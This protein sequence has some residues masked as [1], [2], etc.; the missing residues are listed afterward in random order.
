MMNETISVLRTFFLTTLVIL[1]LW[2]LTYPS[3]VSKLKLYS[4]LLDLHAWLYLQEEL[5]KY[6]GDV[7]EFEANKEIDHHIAIY[8]SGDGYYE[9]KKE[10]LTIQTIWPEWPDVQTLKI[11][12]QPADHYKRDDKTIT[13]NVRIYRVKTSSVSN[14]PTSDYFVVFLRDLGVI[15]VVS[16]YDSLFLHNSSLGLRQVIQAAHEGHKPQYWD[17]ISLNLLRHGYDQGIRKLT[18]KSEALAKLRAEANPHTPG[19]VELFGIQ[20]SIYLFF[21]S[22]G[23]LL[24]A[25]AFAMIG[26]IMALVSADIKVCRHPWIFLLPF[27]RSILGGI[28]E[29]TIFLVLLL[30]AGA[31]LVLLILQRALEVHLDDNSGSILLVGKIGLLF[32]SLVQGI[33][34]WQL[35]KARWSLGKQES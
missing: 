4:E 21:S 18:T 15:R 35:S 30:W 12:L 9:E 25:V 11:E 32:A 16:V 6:I 7:F 27:K 5:D 2:F 19:G 14:L 3:A 8:E 13:D 10:P 29:V 33:V 24:S 31:P 22:I 17:H 1:L 28:L 23:I 20:L 34:V 26:P